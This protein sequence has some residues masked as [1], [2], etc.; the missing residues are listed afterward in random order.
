[1]KSISGQAYS[2]QGRKR[3]AVMRFAKRLLH[4]RRE[5]DPIQLQ[6][7][8]PPAEY[9]EEAAEG[10][11]KVPLDALY[12]LQSI[13]IFGHF[14][15][16]VFLK[17]C[18]HT[19]IIN[20]IAGESLIKVGDPDDSVFIVQSGQV[21]VFLNNPD[22]SSIALK[23]VRKG[24]SVTSLLSFIDVLVVSILCF[25]AQVVASLIEL[26]VCFF[27]RATLVSTKRLQQE[28]WKILK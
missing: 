23:V 19:E 6:V 27:C 1:M 11:E 5:N 28:R 16:P 20:L 14:E 26:S 10:N 21:N 25:M 4:I 22:G 13:R 8:E 9:L 15:K 7:V 17:I 2:G 12:M 3:K 18:K 24:E